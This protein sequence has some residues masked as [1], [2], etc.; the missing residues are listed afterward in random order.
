MNYIL[1]LKN[2]ASELEVEES[3]PLDGRRSR[4]RDAF[5]N[6][7]SLKE[8]FKSQLWIPTIDCFYEELDRR[9]H[10]GALLSIKCIVA[11]NP[12]ENFKNF[13]QEKFWNSFACIP[14]FW[15]FPT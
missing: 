15:M 12:S 10:D 9:F 6:I 5:Q 2:F 8:Y 13:V 14:V 7:L 4:R 1:V 11:L 3:C